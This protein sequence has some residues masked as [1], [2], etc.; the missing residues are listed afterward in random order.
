MNFFTAL[1]A[2]LLVMPINA[3]SENSTPSLRLITVG[4]GV[5]ES[6]FA[7]GR[8]DQIVATDSSS[9]WPPQATALPKVGYARTLAVEGILAF[10]PDLLL[11]SDLAGPPEVLEKIQASGVRV[12]QLPTAPPVKNSLKMLDTLAQELAVPKRGQTLRQSIE[13]ALTRLPSPQQRPRALVLIGGSSGQ[14]MAAGRDTR[15]DAMLQLA[16][17]DNVA[18]AFSGYR[19]VGA[20]SLLRLAPQVIVVPDHAL[21]M[22]GG[23]V[24]ALLE[25]AAIAATPAGQNRHVVVMDGLLLLGMGPRVAQAAQQLQDHLKQPE[26]ANAPAVDGHSGAT[27]KQRKKP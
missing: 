20:E 12:L 21:P 9:T 3:W 16:G 13:Q 22:L 25:Q 27:P 8:G 6:V 24:Q 5:T 4:G 11:V 1:C 10:A 14:M 23:S 2:L 15:A 19:P 18:K 7:L 17:A 26:L